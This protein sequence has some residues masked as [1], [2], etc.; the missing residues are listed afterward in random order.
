M[1][2]SSI[3]TIISVTN[4]IKTTYKT[5]RILTVFATTE[6]VVGKYAKYEE[7]RCQENSS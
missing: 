3:E 5:I 2:K 4:C 1:K 6:K 7:V